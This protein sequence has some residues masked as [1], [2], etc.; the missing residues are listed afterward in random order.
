MFYSVLLHTTICILKLT[1]IK[2]PSP[3]THIHWRYSKRHKHTLVIRPS[4][5]VLLLPVHCWQT[6]SHHRAL[7]PQPSGCQDDA[8]VSL[9]LCAAVTSHNALLLTTFISAST[10]DLSVTTDIRLPL[11]ALFHCLND[12]LLPCAHTLVGVFFVQRCHFLHGWLP[13]N[14]L[15]I[16]M[17]KVS[18]AHST[19][20]PSHPLPTIMPHLTRGN[21]T[22]NTLHTIR[23]CES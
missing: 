7:A 9:H 20:L 23:F 10:L 1:P 21:D 4:S 15:F 14:W 16:Q 12:L 22:I 3:I 8:V 6:G 19:M 11:L 13:L 2:P 18:R 17:P 5:K